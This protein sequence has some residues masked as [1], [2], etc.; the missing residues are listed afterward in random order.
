MAL[1]LLRR[2]LSLCVAPSSL[3]RFVCCGNGITKANKVCEN[4]PHGK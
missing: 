4:W 3:A 1:S 2:S